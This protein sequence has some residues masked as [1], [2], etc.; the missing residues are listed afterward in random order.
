MFSIS[1][2]VWI[3]FNGEGN[4]ALFYPLFVVRPINQQKY[5]KTQL[6]DSHSVINQQIALF[7]MIQH[8]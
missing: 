8:A 1:N 5:L 3:K 7:Y 2:V 4:L 6:F